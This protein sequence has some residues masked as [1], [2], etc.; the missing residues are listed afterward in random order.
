[1]TEYDEE[2]EDEE[3]EEHEHTHTQTNSNSQDPRGLSQHPQRQ[4]AEIMMKN[5]EDDEE[6]SHQHTDSHEHTSDSAEEAKPSNAKSSKK[7][8]E[9]PPAKGL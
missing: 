9:K 5:Q 8:L 2:D 3:D 7:V 1:M 6:Y 4:P